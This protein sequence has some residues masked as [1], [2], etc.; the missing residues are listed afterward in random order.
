MTNIWAGRGIFRQA[1]IAV[2]LLISLVALGTS[3]ESSR[4]EKFSCALQPEFGK[5]TFSEGVDV[6]NT[7]VGVYG[8]A[9]FDN[10]LLL[11]KTQVVHRAAHFYKPVG[12]NNGLTH[13]DFRRE[14]DF[15]SIVPSLP[16]P[17]GQESFVLVSGG[18]R[19]FFILNHPRRTLPL[20]SVRFRWQDIGSE[21]AL[22]GV[23]HQ[24][25]SFGS[26]VCG[27]FGRFGL[28]LQFSDVS[29]CGPR[30]DTSDGYKAQ[31]E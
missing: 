14:S 7:A 21:F 19:Q 25:E 13:F 16:N 17:S 4:C 5:S 3:Y 8:L 9:A 11:L 23:S 6:R 29:Q 30:R 12:R 24:V 10:V 26:G 28:L 22:G 1:T 20:S 18:E 15:F 31:L 2:C 27:V